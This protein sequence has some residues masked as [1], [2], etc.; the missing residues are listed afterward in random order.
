MHKME[1]VCGCKE[2]R[3]PPGFAVEPSVTTQL[4]WGRSATFHGFHLDGVEDLKVRVSPSIREGARRHRCAVTNAVEYGWASGL[5]SIAC[6]WPPAQPSVL[7]FIY[8]APQSH[9][10]VSP[11]QGDYGVAAMAYLPGR[12]ARRKWLLLPVSVMDP[13]AGPFRTGRKAHE[14]I[15]RTPGQLP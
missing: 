10:P 1:Q 11:A 12:R 15:S 7:R 6:G 14:Y 8:A 4:G 5:A 2:F 13:S 9:H 3:P